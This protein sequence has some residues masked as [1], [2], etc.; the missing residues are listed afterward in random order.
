MKVKAFA[1][2]I[3]I[4]LTIALLFL[5]AV[6]SFEAYSFGIISGQSMEPK[7]QEGDLI[8]IKKISAKDVRIGDVIAYD[9][10]GKKYVHEVIDIKVS[11]DQ[12]AFKTNCD[13]ADL[14]YGYIASSKGLIGEVVYVIPKIGLP[15]VYMELFIFA[16]GGVIILSMIWSWARYLVT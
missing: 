3:L 13:P 4:S 12:V 11:S 16:A 10:N 6:M 1:L 7:I 15:I 9:V 5:F 14:I 8:L 2:T